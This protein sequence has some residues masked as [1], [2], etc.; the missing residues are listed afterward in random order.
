[1]TTDALTL[2]AFAGQPGAGKSTLARRLASELRCV[3]LRVDTIEQALRDLLAAEV[4]AEG[5]EIAY[6]I[7]SDNLRLGTSVV[8]D[9]C[10]PIE[11]TRRAWERVAASAGARCVHVEVVC[12]DV[13]EHRRRV[14]T[15]DVDVPGLVLPRWDDVRART[16]EPWTVDRIVVD[17]AGR[18]VDQA[19]AALL[20]S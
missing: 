15:R 4:V 2:Y 12:S 8:A 17:T 16:F 9:S 20:T 3:W 18:S 11:Q 6:R 5:Y 1:M 19:I 13:A 7:A 10:D 14:E